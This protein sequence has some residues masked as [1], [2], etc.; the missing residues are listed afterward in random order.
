[1][2]IPTDPKRQRCMF[3]TNTRFATTR[4]LETKLYSSS[5]KLS[6]LGDKI[7]RE[8]LNIDACPVL[9]STP[10]KTKP[11]PSKHLGNSA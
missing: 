11:C 3:E 10:E 5:G 1:M 6:F 8:A 2:R 9:K 4:N 7:Q